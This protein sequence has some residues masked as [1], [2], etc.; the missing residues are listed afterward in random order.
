M[1]IGYAR[2]STRDQNL[3]MQVIALEKDG[4]ERICQEIVSGAKSD[5]LVLDSLLA[6]LR[7]GQVMVGRLW[8]QS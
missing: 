4:C 2:V 6:Q 8:Y 7:P 3:D 1:K 5:R